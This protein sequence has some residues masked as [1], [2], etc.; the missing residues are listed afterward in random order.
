MMRARRIVE[1]ASKIARNNY[2][3]EWLRRDE[4]GTWEKNAEKLLEESAERAAQLGMTEEAVDKEIANVLALT[5]VRAQI[6]A[7]NKS[8]K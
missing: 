2:S 5:S 6:S 4:F 3:R 1:Q 7:K 8:K